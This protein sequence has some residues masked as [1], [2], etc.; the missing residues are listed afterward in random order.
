MG[1]SSECRQEGSR[2]HTAYCYSLWFVKHALCGR[3]LW[4]GSFR[5]CAVWDQLHQTLALAQLQRKAHACFLC[6]IEMKRLQDY[7]PRPTSCKR[8]CPCRLHVLHQECAAGAPHLLQVC[9]RAAVAV[10]GAGAAAVTAGGSQIRHHPPVP[11][12]TLGGGVAEGLAV[13]GVKQLGDGGLTGQLRVEGAQE[14]AQGL[15]SPRL[16]LL[17]LWHTDMGRARARQLSFARIGLQELQ[18]PDQHGGARQLAW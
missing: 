8:T 6:Y 17:G 14:G 7:G 2:R 1:R 12:G 3:A 13:G 10:L 16:Q 4:L 18:G 9:M 11:F 5:S 15:G